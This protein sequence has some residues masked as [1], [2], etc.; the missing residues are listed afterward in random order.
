MTQ[1]VSQPDGGAGEVKCPQIAGRGLLEPRGQCTEP[2][3]VV[4]E[5]LDAVALGVGLFVEA[6]L[7]LARGVCADDGLHPASSHRAANRVG[8]VASVSDHRLALSVLEELL[9]ERGLV[10]LTRRDF[11]VERTP[12]CV[13]DRVDLG[14]EST[15]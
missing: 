10:L 3:E 2:L 5:D 15:T 8:V 12:L 4:E 1:Q 6:R 11:D 9:G 14:G 13:D 7:A